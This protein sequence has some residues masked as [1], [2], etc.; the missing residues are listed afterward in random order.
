MSSFCLGC[1]TS[2]S[3]EERFCGNCGRDS[4][5][6]ASVTPALDPQVAFGLAPETSGKA[7]FSLICG[8]FSLFP[9]LAIVAVIFGHL[10][11]SEIRKSGGRLV[12]KGLAIAGMVLGYSGF[13]LIATL[14]VIGTVVAVRDRAKILP[15][16]QSMG[17]VTSEQPLAVS[18]LRTLN[19]AEIAYAQAHPETGYTCSINDLSGA[20]RISGDLAQAKTNG[21]TVALK[22][23]ARTMDGG[24]V[25]KYQLVAYPASSNAKLP[26]FCSNQSDVIKVEWSGSPTGCLINGEDF[27]DGQARRDKNGQLATH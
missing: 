3:P 10:S 7:I 16:G 21:Y 20:W 1:G 2:L 23:C 18:A 25:T 9:P 12:G 19:T 15:K 4:S 6:G 27:S 14:I 17:R 5:S 11:L 8:I 26:A 24:P 22:G 13:A